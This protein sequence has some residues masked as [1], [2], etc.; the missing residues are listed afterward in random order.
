MSTNTISN[1]LLNCDETCEVCHPS[2]AVVPYAASVRGVVAY[3]G[4][5]EELAIKLGVPES[6][7]ENGAAVE[8]SRRPPIL[9]ALRRLASFRQPSSQA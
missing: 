6:A 3:R 1:T 8:S 4:T 2:C 5:R 9:S 7:L